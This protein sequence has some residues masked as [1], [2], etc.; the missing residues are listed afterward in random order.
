MKRFIYLLL[1]VLVSTA[2]LKIYAEQCTENTVPFLTQ[3]TV[4]KFYN[5]SGYPIIYKACLHMSIPDKQ[6]A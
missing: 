5:S 4:N 2:F 1:F 6:A 3:F